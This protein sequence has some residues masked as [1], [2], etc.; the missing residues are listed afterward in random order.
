MGGDGCARIFD[1]DSTLGTGE[2][3]GTALRIRG[4][5]QY[6]RRHELKRLKHTSIG[7]HQYTASVSGGGAAAGRQTDAMARLKNRYNSARGYTSNAL[8]SYEA[9]AMASSEPMIIPQK[10]KGAMGN[11]SQQSVGSNSSSTTGPSQGADRGSASSAT[12]DSS[13]SDSSALNVQEQRTARD[14]RNTRMQDSQARLQGILGNARSDNESD[15]SSHSEGATTDTSVR[16]SGSSKEASETTGSSYTNSSYSSYTTTTKSGSGGSTSGSSG[17]STGGTGVPLSVSASTPPVP[18]TPE[19]LSLEEQRQTKLRKA[20]E[21]ALLKRQQREEKA[22]KR[23]E[24]AAASER[25]RQARRERRQVAE[26]SG[27]TARALTMFE[28]T[29]LTAE[30]VTANRTKLSAFLDHHSE[31]PGRYRPLIWRFLLQ[32]PENIDAYEGLSSQGMHQEYCDLSRTYPISDTVVLERLARVCSALTWWSPVFLEFPNLPQM[33][34]PFVVIY[35]S[36]ELSAVES[37]ISEYYSLLCIYPDH[38]LLLCD[39]DEYANTNSSPLS[40]S[41]HILPSFHVLLVGVFMYW[42]Y[43]FFVSYPAEP[44]HIY[45]T[46]DKLLDIHDKRLKYHLDSLLTEQPG[47]LAFTLMTTLFTTILSAP[48]WLKLMDFLVLHFENSTYMLLTPIALLR[49]L[50]VTLLGIDTEKNLLEVVQ[51]QQHYFDMNELREMIEGGVLALS[52]A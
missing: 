2:L 4:P 33:V 11:P 32:L 40:P 12:G 43:S 24:A 28:L 49:M 34:F 6:I 20:S 46:L 30:E 47:K 3:A 9:E 19:Q 29:A 15:P 52:Y 7:H 8:S 18:P 21:A 44:K 42:G 38:S 25:R 10:V 35:G 14:Q 36:D 22:R 1:I 51:Q 16:V 41:I 39:N 45:D 27:I 26:Q 13:S 37:I 23:D 17:T 5:H 31:Y 48:D 50:K